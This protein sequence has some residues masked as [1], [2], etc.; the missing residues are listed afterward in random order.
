[1]YFSIDF[2]SFDVLTDRNFFDAIINLSTVHPS[3]GALVY[4][5]CIE[6]SSLHLFIKPFETLQKLE[7]VCT[8]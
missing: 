1:M 6:V 5:K 2:L 3:D 8:V 4:S 7:I